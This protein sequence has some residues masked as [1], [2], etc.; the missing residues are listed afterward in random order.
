MK[1]RSWKIP[2]NIIFQTSSYFSHVECWHILVWCICE[3]WQMYT[4]I[5]V[6]PYKKGFEWGDVT[7][8]LSIWHLSFSFAS[9][10][11][12]L[13]LY[14]KVQIMHTALFKI[15]GA[16]QGGPPVFPLFLPLAPSCKSNLPRKL[17]CSPNQ[18]IQSIR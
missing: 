2:R 9:L 18:L 16:H 4:S 10:S 14:F 12:P 8:S 7:L 5:Y 15:K 13:S 17:N 6:Q 1:Q 3:M 11:T